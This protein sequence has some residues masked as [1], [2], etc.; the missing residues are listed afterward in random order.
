MSPEEGCSSPE[1][2][3]IHV[4]Y[5]VYT[6]M[7]STSLLPTN[8]P[9]LTQ[10]RVPGR[11]DSVGSAVAVQTKASPHICLGIFVGI[12]HSQDGNGWL[13]HLY[14]LK[15]C[16]PW[17]EHQALKSFV[18][19]SALNRMDINSW[20]LAKIHLSPLSVNAREIVR[21]TFLNTVC[22]QHLPVSPHIHSEYDL[23][24]RSLSSGADKVLRFPLPN[25]ADL[26]KIFPGLIVRPSGTNFADC[27]VG[28]SS[29]KNPSEHFV[30]ITSLPP[31]TVKKDLFSVPFLRVE[32]QFGQLDSGLLDILFM[33]DDALTP[34]EHDKWLS[35]NSISVYT[36][37]LIAHHSHVR[38][39][40]TGCHQEYDLSCWY[41][42]EDKHSLIDFDGANMFI[43]C[44]G[45][46]Y[47]ARN[48]SLSRG[49]N[50]YIGERMGGSGKPS[51][52][53]KLPSVELDEHSSRRYF[54]SDWKMFYYPHL[55]SL[56][57]EVTHGLGST[58]GIQHH[59]LRFRQIL[60]GLS[61]KEFQSKQQRSL[62]GYR[63]RI[64]TQGTPGKCF[65]F[66]NTSHVDTSDTISVG[67]SDLGRLHG[68]RS[69]L[70]EK[71]GKMKLA[72]HERRSLTRNH[73]GRPTGTQV[74]SLEG[75]FTFWAQK[76]SPGGSSHLIQIILVPSQASLSTS[77]IGCKLVEKLCLS[78]LRY[79]YFKICEQSPLGSEVT[80]VAQ[81]S[82]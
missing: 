8:I 1:E 77:Q 24:I 27:I 55:S 45:C 16:Q 57:N 9:T 19:D 65:G 33:L 59:Y 44:F 5:G 35:D 58:S 70:K 23:C 50:L 29:K 12:G 4:S 73:L 18:W 54:R 47:G 43:H 31:I 61:A 74:E 66:C 76:W 49:Q 20:N 10:F 62:M 63:M 64:V 75:G 13:L 17:E 80:Q 25:S 52:G 37:C 68:M 48:K 71:Q 3:R 78:V 11:S 60:S 2:L 40:D 46:G 51:P 34:D 82:Y 32:G 36:T 26:T 56:L 69:Q 41:P 6:Q 39:T 30:C 42:P 28:P 53:P 38:V 79:D 7:V 15:P 67:E 21:F 81:C 22:S 72:Q 14:V